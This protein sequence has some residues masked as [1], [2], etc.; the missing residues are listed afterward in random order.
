MIWLLL[1]NYKI[2]NFAFLSSSK[3]L[4]SKIDRDLL[5]R[6]LSAF[7]PFWNSDNSYRIRIIYKLKKGGMDMLKILQLQH[8]LPL[9]ILVIDLSPSYVFQKF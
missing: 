4:N 6:I 9:I 3:V 2:N 7:Q 5:L 8:F 1:H